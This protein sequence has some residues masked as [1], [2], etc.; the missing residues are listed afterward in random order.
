[1]SLFEVRLRASSDLYLGTGHG[2][3]YSRASAAYVPSSTLVGAVAGQYR[4]ARTRVVDADLENLLRQ[5]TFSDAIVDVRAGSGT[6]WDG[7]ARPLD[8]MMCK[9]PTPQCPEQG[10]EWWELA[11]G[12]CPNGCAVNAAKGERTTNKVRVTRVALDSSERARD[13]HLF[14]REALDA[15]DRTLVAWVAGSDKAIKEL[16]LV[17][18]AALRIGGLRSVAGRVT[19]ESIGSLHFDDIHATHGLLRVELLSP[20][21]FVDEYGFPS[22]T[23][24]R[25]DLRT[26]LG[27]ESPEVVRSF[28]RWTTLGGWAVA[29]SVPKPEDPAVIAHSVYLVRVPTNAKVP[30]VVSNLGWRTFEGNGWARIEPLDE[31]GVELLERDEEGS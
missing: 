4:A 7:V 28:V 11:D 22:P 3:G 23:P 13:D 15:R 26:A 29:A 14:Q 6:M 18:G 16:G 5:V 25:E 27:V 30:A 31:Q 8:R 24:S 17:G 20:G 10:W 12:Q 9:Y 2:S 19:V 21:V 1:M